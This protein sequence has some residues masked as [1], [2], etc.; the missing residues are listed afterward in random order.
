MQSHLIKGIVSIKNAYMAHKN[1][2]T[3]FKSKSLLSVL[4]LLYKY[5]YIG[6]Y[7]IVQEQKIQ[8]KLKYYQKQ[9]KT[10]PVVK[11]IKLFYSAKK[12]LLYQKVPYSQAPFVHQVFFTNKGTL[13][14]KECQQYNVGGVKLMEIA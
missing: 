2:V 14:C 11:N 6:E 4:K 1:T 7:N 10:L 5:K 13:T 12:K 9:Q 3:I 8:I